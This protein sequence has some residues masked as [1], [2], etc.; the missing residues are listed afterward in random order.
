[1]AN[2]LNQSGEWEQQQ[3]VLFHRLAEGYLG[4][5]GQTS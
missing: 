2:E 1:M 3:V 4:D 5:A